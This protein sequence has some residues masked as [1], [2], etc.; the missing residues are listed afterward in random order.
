MNQK[1]SGSTIPNSI[2]ADKPIW[3][4]IRLAPYFALIPN[5]TAA[6]GLQEAVERVQ[7]IDL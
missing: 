7:V 6:K 2:P 3:A 1:M 5:Q 4:E